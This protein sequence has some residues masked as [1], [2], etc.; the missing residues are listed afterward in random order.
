LKRGIWAYT[1]I[2][3]LLCGSAHAQT[4]SFWNVKVSTNLLLGGA[5]LTTSNGVL[6]IN[7][8]SI[9]GGT[10]GTDSNTVIALIAAGTALNASNWLG[11]A[12]ASNWLHT[13]FYPL[14][15]NPS[16]YLTAIDWT[17]N[18]SNS[19]LQ[20][21]I[22][23]KADTNGTY[24]LLSCGTAT[25]AGTAGAGWPTSWPSTAITNPPWAA[26]NSVRLVNDVRR[27]GAA[28]NGT[29]N[30]SAAFQS[31]FDA[32][33]T[34][35]LP[36]YVPTGNYVLSNTVYYSNG[37][38]ML[39]NGVSSRLVVPSVNSL[40]LVT[41]IP[42]SA[43]TLARYCALAPKATGYSNLLFADWSMDWTD[44]VS[45]NAAGMLLWG[46]NKAVVR[47]VSIAGV[48]PY[49]LASNE[50]F[51]A[52]NIWIA[53]CTNVVVR[54]GLWTNGGYRCIG[55]T[56]CRF[57][58]IVGVQTAN[59]A[60]HDIELGYSSDS[61]IRGCVSSNSSTLV[62]GVLSVHSG[63][64]NVV[65]DNNVV[66]TSGLAGYPT[67]GAVLILSDT[68]GFGFGAIGSD[69]IVSG[70]RITSAAGGIQ[71]WATTNVSVVA[72]SVNVSGGYGISVFPS[73]Q[74]I[75]NSMPANVFVSGNTV[76]S[77]G[78]TYPAILVE[79]IAS[80]TLAGNFA[81]SPVAA[82]TVTRARNGS[83]LPVLANNT[84]IGRVTGVSPPLD[85][86]ANIARFTTNKITV[87]YAANIS[88]NP[89]TFAAWVYPTV[90]TNTSSYLWAAE[91]TNNVVAV[92]VRITSSCQFEYLHA[93]TGTG[94][95]LYRS[96]IV[97]V[98][99]EWSHVS[100][101]K[102]GSNILFAVNGVWTNATTIQTSAGTLRDTLG[103]WV[104][105][106]RTA[107]NARQYIGAMRD[108]A[109]WPRALLT[110]DLFGI[111]NKAPHSLTGA[112]YISR[113]GT[114]NIAVIP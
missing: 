82:L 112:V 93:D 14:G 114:A 87:A 108:V 33:A 7:G 36:V 35:S 20:G 30:D 22:N 72:N 68:D 86:V 94:A 85:F 71:A 88:T 101:S 6:L 110:N 59:G 49:A 57:L 9:T 90:L 42:W 45:T 113:D 55:S 27:F 19:V 48:S 66:Q 21:S 39:G 73:A 15:S 102:S 44:T 46:A 97:L 89:F 92:G 34:N 4:N 67:W 23:A 37:V 16:N 18:P 56:E 107:D 103:N 96:P 11:W 99:N 2:A 51:R 5:T 31:A 26:T 98:S 47:D 109:I 70:N 17:A 65:S 84:F 52:D 100:V 58:D 75:S 95:N 10:S 32:A 38:T 3:G 62:H 77:T 106:S 25:Y 64:R 54:G 28:G 8:A 60:V 41:N 40:T 53:R 29:N 74:G 12:S 78:T 13:A 69:H 79:N 1:L 104:F 50:N 63:A 105:G 83:S 81:S 111:N 61:S 43:S 24:A 91:D 76:I 80:C